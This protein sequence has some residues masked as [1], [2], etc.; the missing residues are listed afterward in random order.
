MTQYILYA[1][2][3][4]YFIRKVDYKRLKETWVNCLK[5]FGLMVC[6]KIIAVFL[7]FLGRYDI[8]SDKVDMFLGAPLIIFTIYK[9][10]RLLNK[11]VD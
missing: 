1:W 6:G 10:A 4:Y 3:F 8:S 9:I 5:G 11:R 7:V 2:G